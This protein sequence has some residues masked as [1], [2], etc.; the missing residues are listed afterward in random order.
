MDGKMFRNPHGILRM[1]N[2]LKRT[3]NRVTLFRVIPIALVFFLAG[4]AAHKRE[5]ST[6]DA[7]TSPTLTRADFLSLTDGSVPDELREAL[8]VRDYTFTPAQDGDLPLVKLDLF[9][10]SSE[11]ELAFQIRT[12]FFREAGTMIDASEWATVHIPPRQ[13]HFYRCQ[14]FSPFAA[15]EQVQLRL[16]HQPST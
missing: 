5:K 6:M 7:A 9:N 2:Q 10:V 13:S 14:S 1:F 16:V 8:E 15:S 4:C 12:V 3:E 11:K